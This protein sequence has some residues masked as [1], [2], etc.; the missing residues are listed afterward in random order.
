MARRQDGAR[1]VARLS[2]FLLG[3]A[4]HVEAVMVVVVVPA[5]K[6]DVDVLEKED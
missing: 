6:V 2:F 5:I 4:L 3:C 1:A